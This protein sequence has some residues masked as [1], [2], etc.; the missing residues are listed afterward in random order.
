M[1]KVCDCSLEESRGCHRERDR[2][3]RLRRHDS[4][5][6]IYTFGKSQDYQFLEFNRCLEPRATVPC[7]RPRPS[8]RK[9]SFGSNQS[10][11]RTPPGVRRGFPW[12]DDPPTFSE[13]V[14]CLTLKNLLP[15]RRVS[16]CFRFLCAPNDISASGPRL[17]SEEKRET[18]FLGGH[19]RSRGSGRS[20]SSTISVSPPSV[21]HLPPVSGGQG[22]KSPP[23][24]PSS[25]SELARP[26]SSSSRSPCT[27]HA[28][29]NQAKSGLSGPR[30]SGWLG[31]I[32]TNDSSSISGGGQRN[33]LFSLSSA[34]RFFFSRSN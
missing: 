29:S 9:G 10:S 11:G 7:T 5:P 13:R 3:T 16:A 31:S 28:S 24:L 6:Y 34:F 25:V 20:R 26:S 8:T 4:Y 2:C 1:G 33:C 14:L 12:D 30:R 23:M 27:A 18:G 17:Q 15:T 21:P 22:G 32:T 19:S